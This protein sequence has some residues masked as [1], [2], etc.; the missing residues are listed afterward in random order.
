[1]RGGTYTPPKMS[2]PKNDPKPTE[3]GMA[4]GDGAEKRKPGRPTGRTL[5]REVPVY[6]SA[7]GEELAKRLAA[8]RGMPVARFFRTLLEEEAERE[9]LREEMERSFATMTPA[10]VREYLESLRSG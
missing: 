7:A 3:Q 8:K 9:R 6:L 5:T 2:I 10:D 1:M 4:Y